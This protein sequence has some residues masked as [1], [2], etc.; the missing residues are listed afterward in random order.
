MMRKPPKY[1]QG[2][3]D[4]HGAARWY[5]RRPG[6]DRVPLPG[7][8]WT[9]EFMTAYEAA[10]K[11]EKQTA[12]AGA[13]KTAPGTVAALVASYYRSAEHLNLKPIAQRTYRS[14]IEP[15]REQHGDKVTAKLK[16][17]HVK[18]IIAKPA[19][20]P[21]VANN[22]LKAIKILMRHAIDS[23]VRAD[24]P[25]L[26]VKKLRSG[27][28]GYRTWSEEEIEQFYDRH[29]IGSRARLALDLLLYTGQRRADVVCM[30]RQHLRDGVLTI[31][32]SKTGTEVELPLHP[33]LRA[34]LDALPQ[35]NMT[36]LLTDY[37]KPFAVAG[38]GNWFRD[39]VVEAK[40]PEGLS[41]HGLRK[42]ACRR[43]AELGCSAPQI[44][45]Y[46]GHK[47]LK[48]VQTYIEAAN[49]LGLARQALQMQVAADENRTRTVKPS[50]EV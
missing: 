42:A 37:G 31:R 48:E 46:S 11:G 4:R 49:R 27:P 15:F 1:C 26:G 19:S 23:G 3:L 16:R 5:F 32:Q 36:F 33:I 30:G 9:P 43:F 7:L 8:P 22:W 34:S 20:R 18:A 6:Y 35:K 40:L 2:F 25:T 39:R 17:E 10:A 29:P 14:T 47:N 45:A 41:A 50:G 44:M 28:S 38:F 12:G 13:A 24:D 21:A